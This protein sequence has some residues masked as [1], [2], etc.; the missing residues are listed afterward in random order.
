MTFVDVWSDLDTKERL[1]VIEQVVLLE[2]SLLSLRFQTSG[3][4]YFPDDLSEEDRSRSVPL[5]V[6][7]YEF[8]LQPNNIILSDPLDIVGHVDWQH[9][10]IA[11][12]CLAAGMPAQFQNYGDPESQRFAQPA[13][14]LPSDSDS[15]TP[16]EQE[17]ATRLHINTPIQFGDKSVKRIMDLHHKQ[18]EM[19]HVLE[20][21]PNERLESAKAFADEIKARI[22]EA[23]DPAERRGIEETFRFDNFDEEGELM[24]HK[25]VCNIA[26]T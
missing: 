1:K 11:P 7:V 8:Y 16:E 2:E 13:R 4:I 21:L 17:S 14:E 3:S 9:A 19:D 15:W 6:E 10:T 22:I 20:Q 26:G 24:L 5:H 18:Q 12:L 23:A 25:E